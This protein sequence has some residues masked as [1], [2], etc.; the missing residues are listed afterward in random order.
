VEGQLTYDSHGY[1]WIEYLLQDADQI[2][3]LSVEEDDRVEV[4]WLKP[5][6]GLEISHTPPAQITV[7]GV[8]FQLQ[9]L[10]TAQMTHLGATLNRRAQQCR[11]FDYSSVD[12]SADSF[13]ESGANANADQQVLS[14]ED[15][16]GEF[17]ITMG[18][19]I[20]PSALVLL[21]GDGRHVYDR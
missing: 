20:R 18:Y 11:Y 17:E 2:R 7:A 8:N 6:Q 15:W 16:G 1:I 9:E 3:W 5:V 21:P 13:A 4:C 14:I 10:D 12:G 19:Q